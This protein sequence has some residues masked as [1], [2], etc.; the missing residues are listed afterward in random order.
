MRK[1][2]GSGSRVLV[3]VWRWKG[4]QEWSWKVQ[5]SRAWRVF[6]VLWVMVLGGLALVFFWGFR[7]L[8]VGREIGKEGMQ[9]WGCFERFWGVFEG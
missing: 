8:G 4:L 1:G 2:L 9:V 6:R 7:V 3:R 5:D